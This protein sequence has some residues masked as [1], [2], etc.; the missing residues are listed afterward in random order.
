[1]AH[2]F[3]LLLPLLCLVV[4]LGRSQ[5]AGVT[6]QAAQ[7]HVVPLQQFP[8]DKRFATLSGDSTKPGAL[9]VIRI[10]SEAGYIVMPHTHPEDENIVVV[11]GTW[12]LGMG[13]RFRPDQLETMEVGTYGLVG[14]GM[15]H[16]ARSTTDAVVQVHGLGPF[17][18]T[19]VIP[20]FIWNEA[21]VFLSKS[22]VSVGTPTD[23][24][25]VSCF[26][27]KLG[28][29]VR[30]RDREGIII[31]AECTPGQL[32]QYRIESL[33]GK[34]FWAMQQEMATR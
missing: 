26:P 15:A 24:P 34:R 5:Q 21:G 11:N 30:S 6:P 1:M 32:T 17:T 29:H 2:E 9:Y 18:T 31:G 25:P 14:K 28:S 22:A 10:H 7:T 27:L 33:E 8:R 13:D 20:V 23:A 16:F 4:P 3:N 12:A 19:W